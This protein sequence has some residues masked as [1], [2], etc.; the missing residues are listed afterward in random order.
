[1][2]H[3]DAL[4]QR[5]VQLLLAAAHKFA[6]GF[7]QGDEGAA[8]QRLGVLFVAPHGP[9]ADQGGFGLAVW[10]HGDSPAIV[11]FVFDDL[12]GPAI[13]APQAGF[14]GFEG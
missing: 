8:V 6:G 9:G 4:V 7:D 3:G 5:G 10:C 11:V 14:L 1:M 2:C 12:G 13:T